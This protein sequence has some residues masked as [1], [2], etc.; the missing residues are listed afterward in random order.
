[1]YGQEEYPYNRAGKLFDVFFLL[2]CLFREMYFAMSTGRVVL[3]VLV[4]VIFVSTQRGALAAD[5]AANCQCDGLDTCL[6]CYKCLQI[7]V[8]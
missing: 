7:Y 1:M 8:D 2:L 5:S 4:G 6:P 3:A